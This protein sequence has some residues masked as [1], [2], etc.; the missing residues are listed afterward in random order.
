M[1]SNPYDEMFRNIA[2]L[3]ERLLNDLPTGDPR[4]IGFTIIAGPGG[5][6]EPFDIDDADG[7]ETDVEVIEGEDCIYITAEVDTHASG[8]PYVTFQ[9]DS[10][11][12]CTGS[13]EE[14]VIEL[15]C[16]IDASHS[17]YNVQNGVIDAVCQKSRHI[18]ATS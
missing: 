9:S 10:V 12:L 4:V 5:M 16:E 7:E 1:A 11:T 3:M 6:P 14:T 17:F 2:R 8:K 18:S 13:D 15:D